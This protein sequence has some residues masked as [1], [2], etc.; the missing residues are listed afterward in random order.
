[1]DPFL[2][3][4]RLMPYGNNFVTQGWA[5]CSGQ[6]LL[7][8]QFPALYALLRL[9]Y[10]GN[11]TTTFMLPNLNGRAVMGPSGSYPPGSAVGTESVTLLQ[12]QL[13]AHTHSLTGGIGVNDQLGQA[14]ATSP[15]GAYFAAESAEAYGSPPSV[16][17][18]APLL[19]GTTQ[20]AGGGQP[21]DNR[22]PY[23][24]LGYFIALQGIYP[25]QP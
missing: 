16:G 12:A 14:T 7:I 17:T 15:Q 8:K 4:I 22:M 10:G 2:G 3:E 24:V 5:P 21:H 19:S 23:L 20:V 18:T 1:M 9:T 6:T 11:G 13:P 25:Q